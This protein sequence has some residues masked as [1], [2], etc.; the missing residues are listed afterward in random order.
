MGR[1]LYKFL[2]R[3]MKVMDDDYTIE[4]ECHL[5]SHIRFLR[6]FDGIKIIL[7]E[8]NLDYEDNTINP[9]KKEIFVQKDSDLEWGTDYKS[10]TIY[11]SKIPTVFFLAQKTDY[12]LKLEVEDYYD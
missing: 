5:W 2:D 10:F 7:E 1:S 6:T 9:L 11:V 4:V 8:D 12:T 3:L